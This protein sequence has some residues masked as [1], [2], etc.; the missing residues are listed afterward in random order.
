MRLVLSMM[1]FGLFL[2]SC[3]P[4]SIS[5]SFVDEMDD[6]GDEYLVAGKNFDVLPGDSGAHPYQKE[7]MMSRTPD[8]HEDYPE[9][10]ERQRIRKELTQKLSALSEEQQI[11]FRRNEHLF[12]ND[13]QKLYFLGLSQSE[14]D[15]Y[16]VSIHSKKIS[17]TTKRAPASKF[18]YSPR[19]SREVFMGMPKDQVVNLWGQP[20]RVDVAGDPRYENERWTFYENGQRKYIYFAKGR[21]EGW[22]TE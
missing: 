8:R 9:W 21:V 15:D 2:T 7:D 1:I 6:Q 20:H 12:A 3:G 5:R 13:S 19:A 14:R 22:V 16:L 18:R 11:W 17:S 4:I 10:S